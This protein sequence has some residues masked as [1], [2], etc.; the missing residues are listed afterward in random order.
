MRAIMQGLSHLSVGNRLFLGFGL[1]CLLTLAVG[2]SGGWAVGLMGDSHGRTRDLAELQTEAL[3]LQ[4]A[5]RDFAQTRSNEAAVKV[6]RFIGKLAERLRSH[7]GQFGIEAVEEA[8][9]TYAS[10]FDRFDRLQQEVRTARG[11]MQTQADEVRRTFEVVEQDFFDAAEGLDIDAGATISRADAISQ[12]NSVAELMRMLLGLR[13]LEFA[14]DLAPSADNFE[15][16]RTYSAA[17]TE[18]LDSLRR[19]VDGPHQAALEEA[20]GALQHYIGAFDGFR[21]GAESSVASQARMIEQADR[22]QSAVVE[23]YEAESQAMA[24]N[25]QRFQLA[26]AVIS[27]FALLLGVVAAWVIRHLTLEP[28]R[29]TLQ[30]ASRVADGDLGD[31]ARVVRGDEFGTLQEA[32]SAMTANL[33]NLVGCIDAGVRRLGLVTGELTQ[34]SGDGLGESQRQR[35][36]AEQTA[37]AMQQ[38]TASTRSV[39]EDSAQVSEAALK[40]NDMASQ[41]EQLMRRMT[42]QMHQLSDGLRQTSGSIALLERESRASVEV[43][44]VI[45]TLAE[46]TNLL[47]LNAAIEAARAG[48][49]GRGF[50]VVAE[51][52]RELAGRTQTSASEIETTL[53]SWLD[54]TSRVVKEVNAGL[55][56]GDTCVELAE[57]AGQLL[58]RIMV[59]VAAIEARISQIATATEQQSVV[60]A[61]VSDSAQRVQEMAQS[62]LE[63]THQID[64]ATQDL[65]RLGEDLQVLTQRF[66]SVDSTH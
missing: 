54:V 17:L 52:V 46:Q 50:A 33:R 58:A 28:L 56:L 55:A 9:A 13:T 15:A 10:E 63:N 26:V 60:A 24:Q 18:T 32:M 45:K 7:A 41:G 2:F 6:R 1:S 23:L 21:L 16:W 66:R 51:G 40:A 3:R 30:L 25:S 14:Y 22:M 29:D 47:A 31:A 8:R 43:L 59:E 36:E 34:L 27:L 57:D 44:G 48:E 61:Q 53:Q 49:Q 38:V 20:Q 11:G 42:G 5:Q 39:A 65:A 12:A 37:C 64:G 4:V 35:A 62:A 19:R